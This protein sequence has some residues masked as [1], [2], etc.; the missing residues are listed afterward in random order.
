MAAFTKFEEALKSD[1]PYYFGA[2]ITAVDV[3]FAP[4]APRLSFLNYFRGVTLPEAKFG[5]VNNTLRQCLSY[6]SLLILIACPVILSSSLT[7]TNT[8]M[9]WHGTEKESTDYQ[10][11]LHLCFNIKYTQ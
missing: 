3:A 2:K 1:S 7:P 4:F 6:R 8:M 10:L 5:K 9:Y 11:K